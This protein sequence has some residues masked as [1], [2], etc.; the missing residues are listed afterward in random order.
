MKNS[1]INKRHLWDIKNPD[2]NQRAIILKHLIYSKTITSWTAIS[3]YRITWL[4]AV[5]HALR[6]HYNIEMEMVMPRKHERKRWGMMPFGVYTY[7]GKK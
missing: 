1:E 3:K 4:S 6:V 7:G 2:G 5:I